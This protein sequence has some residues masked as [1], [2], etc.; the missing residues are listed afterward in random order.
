MEDIG[1]MCLIRNDLSLNQEHTSR[2]LHNLTS[3]K[4]KQK[5]KVESIP[6][7]TISHYS[8]AIRC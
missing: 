6:K 2:N 3:Y 8:T 1:Q 4:H 5:D 7:A